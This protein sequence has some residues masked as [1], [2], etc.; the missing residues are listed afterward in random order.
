M[1]SNDPSLSAFENRILTNVQEHGCHINYVFDDEGEE[2][3][4]AYS[5]G[6]RSTANQPEVIVFGLGQELMGF[7]I[8]QLLSKCRKGLRLVN[9]LCVESLIEG[10][11]CIVRTV[12]PSCIEEEYF[13]SAM[14]FHE[15]M[16]ETELCEA[17]QIV[18]PAAK[19]GKFPWE[20]NCS[21]EVISL[22][23]AL[24]EP[25]DCV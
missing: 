14:W 5:V 23:P 16:L 9:W 8:N 19:S 6:F 18:W 17:V 10:H 3:D 2:P 1:R 20:P 11:D 12:H 13:N 22:Q 25:R 15:Y 7:I 24:Y 21:H 4:Y